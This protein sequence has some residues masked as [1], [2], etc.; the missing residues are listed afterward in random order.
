MKKRRL[1]CLMTVCDFW[2][3]P[4]LFY[5][6]RRLE[7]VFVALA[8][9]CIFASLLSELLLLYFQ[10]INRNW[11]LLSWDDQ[12][13][14]QILCTFCSLK[15]TWQCETSYRTLLENFRLVG[16]SNN[17]QV[18]SNK[19]RQCQTSTGIAKSH[20]SSK[21]ICYSLIYLS[22]SKKYYPSELW[23]HC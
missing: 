17:Q 19:S 8:Q 23:Q 5:P 22:D 2:F 13:S 4:Y 7:Y 18:Y 9:T 16:S 6:C 11:K 10:P 21:T 20:N 14:P 3:Y 1:M 12:A 15:N